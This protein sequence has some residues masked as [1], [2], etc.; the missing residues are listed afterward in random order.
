[1]LLIL[2]RN[3]KGFLP[4]LVDKHKVYLHIQRTKRVLHWSQRAM[5]GQ[6]FFQNK[7][8]E[9]INKFVALLTK[10]KGNGKM[11]GKMRLWYS[12][13]LYSTY[14]KLGQFLFYTYLLNCLNKDTLVL[15]KVINIW[16]NSEV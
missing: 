13:A 16:T 5:P 10:K 12:S 4:T 7:P 6:P 1:M 2:Q 3:Q 11:N 9:R 8:V 14:K 15:L